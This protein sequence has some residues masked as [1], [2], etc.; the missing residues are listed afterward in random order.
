MG[1]DNKKR[2]TITMVVILHSI[3]RYIYLLAEHSDERRAGQF[4]FLFGTALL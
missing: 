3:P 4:E 1:K 2:E